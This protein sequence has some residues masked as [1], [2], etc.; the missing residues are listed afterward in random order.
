MDVNHVERE[1][2]TELP[3]YLAAAWGKQERPSRGPKPALS[4]DRIVAAGVALAD[5]EGLAAVSMSRVAAEVGAKPMSLYRY[6]DSKDDLLVLMID[7]A[8]GPA[9]E[10]DAP[11]WRAGLTE[12][13]WAYLDQ[14]RA[15]PWIMRVPIHRPPSTP[16]QLRWL[17]SGLRVLKEFTSDHKMGTMLLLSGYVRSYAMLTADIQEANADPDEMMVDYGNMLRALVDAAEFPELAKVIAAGAFDHNPDEEPDAD[18]VF[19]LE[20]ILDGV[21]RIAG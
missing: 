16:K 17:E 21:A 3:S 12:W 11:D 20:R 19:G 14:L 4:L 5:A 1:T 7:H 18:F 13:S 9:P 2:M 15:H 6:V 8:G 10:I